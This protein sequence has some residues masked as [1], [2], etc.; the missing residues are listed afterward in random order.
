MLKKPNGT[1]TTHGERLSYARGC[2]CDRCRAANN[3]YAKLSAYRRETNNNT[4]IPAARIRKRLNDLAQQGIGTRQVAH[5]TGLSRNAIQKIKNGGTQHV[6]IET[7]KKIL[8]VDPFGLAPSSKHP[9]TL[10][11]R[12]LQGLVY[13]GYPQTELARACGLEP[14]HLNVI[15]HQRRRHVTQDVHERIE[16]VFQK[17]HM[18]PGPSPRSVTIAK[19]N[20]WVS[21]LSWADQ[22]MGQP[23][24]EPQ[25]C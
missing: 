5:L 23:N 19:K 25:F 12:K 6:F 16:V 13:L 8:S 9:A 22:E 2:R 3:R 1:P 14:G 21:P 18:V 15:I 11:A 20:G 7:A 10:S 4:T 17:L 24:A